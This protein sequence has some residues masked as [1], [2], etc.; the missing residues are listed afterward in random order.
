MKQRTKKIKTVLS[1]HANPHDTTNGNTKNIQYTKAEERS[2]QGSKIPC[3]GLPW[4]VHELVDDHN[5]A[6]STYKSKTV[7]L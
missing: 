4:E 6:S 3:E 2:A 7:T 5:T 1:E